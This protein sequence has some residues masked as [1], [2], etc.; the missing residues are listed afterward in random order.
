MN[1]TILSLLTALIS[2][3]ALAQQKEVQ[4]FSL[5]QAVEYA[6][7]Y[8][9]QLKNSSLDVLAAQKKVNE[10]LASGIPNVSATAS[11]LNNIQIPT[12]QLPNF[13]KPSLVGSAVGQAEAAFKQQNPSATEEQINEVKRQT[14][15]TVSKEIPNIIEAQFG[16]K[17]S[18][19]G[20]ITASQLLFDG[21]FLMGVK[22]S[23]EYV[24]LAKINLKRTEI[25]TEVSVSKAY[26]M[27]LLTK[28]NLALI[29][30]NLESLGKLKFD[31]EKMAN[32]GLIDKSEYDRIQLQYSS[33]EIQ[34]AQILDLEKTMILVLKI[35]MGLASQDAIELTDN[36]NNLYANSKKVISTTSIS[37]SNRVE[38]QLAE[39][40]IKLNTLDK[41]RNQYAYTPSLAIFLTHQ[42][43]SFGT[44][45]NQ[46]GNQWFPG[47]FWGLNLNIPIFDGLKTNAKIQQSEI[48][49]LKAKNDMKF[50]ES[51]LDQEYFTAKAS[52]ERTSKLLDIQ[53]KNLALAQDIQNRIELKYKNGLGSSLELSVAQRDV[54]TA[55]ASYLTSMYDY[56]VAQ[57]DLR[58]ALGDIR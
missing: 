55:R 54:E 35:Q 16:Q 18:A 41:K 30:A 39:Q 9:L 48:N 19:S 42:Q 22:A 47:T 21:G 15:E 57:L 31:M 37:Y 44:R 6:R 56:F 38:Y 46:L 51:A 10:I 36:L 13:L 43:N 52:Y 49:I 40:A 7:K 33:L 25:E 3:G 8:N 29:D 27:A 1:K 5:Q 26:Y 58:K 17:F 32:T 45:F 34:R 11:F 50:L 53:E 23:K 28:T 4:R 2:L 12:Q 24:G 14:S 20:S